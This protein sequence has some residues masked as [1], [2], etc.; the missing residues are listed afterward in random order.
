M[1]KRAYR[2][3]GGTL[4]S[5]V[6]QHNDFV[7]GEDSP[8]DFLE[9]CIHRIKKRDHKIKAFLALDFKYARKA[10]RASAKR[11]RRGTTLSLL[12]GCPVAVKDIIDTERMATT[13]GSRIFHRHKAHIDAACV[14]ALRR[15]G[16]IVIGKTHTTEFAVGA[17]AP[18]RNPWRRS[19]TPG[20]S[21]SGSA[22]AVADAMVPLALG[23]QT[24]GSIL[25][26]A[27]F[28]GAVGFKPSLGAIPSAGVH[29]LSPSLDHVGPIAASVE[30]AWAGAIVMQRTF[31][32]GPGAGNAWFD[33]VKPVKA[34]R[35]ARIDHLIGVDERAPQV[36][37]EFDRFIA[38]LERAG[39]HVERIDE[40]SELGQLLGAANAICVDIMRYEI[41][42][43]LSIYLERYRKQIGPRIRDH[44]ANGEAMDVAHYRSRLA[45][46]LELQSAVASV[47]VDGFLLPAASGAAPKGLN[48]TGS[49]TMLAPWTLVG[50][51]AWSLPLLA[52]DGL[53]FGVQLCAAPG[54]DTSL[55]A[56]ANW[57]MRREH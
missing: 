32:A 22:A 18:T 36:Q 3:D 2:P 1:A 35:V 10:A 14:A 33:P 30:D 13:M 46:R 50:G 44:L 42:Y 9:R 11:Y 25:R 24:M 31:G 48:H 29:P 39:V 28:C 16:A 8:V 23:T 40:H 52:V 55:A 19:H 34:S 53:P 15:A 4:S 12:D 51:P 38:A 5:F 49:R 57:L 6:A 17:S 41:R 26:P 56:I 7:S 37:E 21:S 47:R 45:Q 20:G 43:P 27:S 54:E